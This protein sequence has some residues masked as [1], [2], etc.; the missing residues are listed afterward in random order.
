MDYQKKQRA[1]KL[2][3]EMLQQKCFKQ[4]SSYYEIIKQTQT[5]RIECSMIDSG[6]VFKHDGSHVV[7][8]KIAHIPILFHRS[9]QR[10]MVVFVAPFVATWLKH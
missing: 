8:A 10:V 6:N 2:I 9:Q 4:L 5:L 3:F 7:A 1:N